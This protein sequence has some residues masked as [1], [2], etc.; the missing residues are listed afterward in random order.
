[1]KM[2]HLD[3]LMQVLST[4]AESGDT[5]LK[6]F[7]P[8]RYGGALQGASMVQLASAPILAMRHFSKTKT[9]PDELVARVSGLKN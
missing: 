3:A 5:H 1:M 2:N 6:E 9:L 4:F 8:K 7:A